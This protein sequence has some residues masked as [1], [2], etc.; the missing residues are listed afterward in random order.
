[1][2][3]RFAVTLVFTLLCLLDLP[4]SAQS[5][6]DHNIIVVTLDGFR[7]QELFS[8]ADSSVL[9]NP[10]Y[11]KNDSVRSYFWNENEE[12]RRKKLMPFFWNT[13]A[14]EG[15]LYG[16][17]KYNN[18]VDC[19]N[20][21]WF[22][23]PGYSEMFTGMVD[24]GIKSNRKVVNRNT[25][26]FEFIK[27]D[28][29]FTGN[30]GA[31]STWD[32][33]P[34]VLR[35]GNCGIDT[36]DC[37]DAMRDSLATSTHQARVKPHDDITFRRAM[38]YLQQQRPRIIFISFDGTDEHGHGG[39]YDQYL[40][41]AH[42]IDSKLNELWQWIQS[43]DNYRNKTTLFITTDHGRGHVFKK[44]WRNHGRLTPGSNHMWMAVIGPETPALGE[45]KTNAHYFQKQVA[46]TLAAFM[47]LNYSNRRPVGARINEMLQPKHF[48]VTG[49][50]VA[51]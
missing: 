49:A 32:V 2:I 8:G 39:H 24:K 36:E 12:Q 35:A 38:S 33:I 23:Y 17:R 40:L 4:S 25:N 45:L 34:Y 42:Q 5:L 47:G 10:S 7:W 20:P 16:N 9:F 3:Q 37:A 50:G 28:P 18:R 44:S 46:S 27:N 13:I 31:F 21:Y 22:S 6:N 14:A 19:A 43:Q 29:A 30:I 26:V 51:R 48:V 41:S 11:S 15:Q 1:M